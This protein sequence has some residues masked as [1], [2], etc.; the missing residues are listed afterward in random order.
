MFVVAYG[1]DQ[2]LF[3]KGQAFREVRLTYF[4]LC[5]PLTSAFGFDKN[6][7]L[8]FRELEFNELSYYKGR[9]KFFVTDMNSEDH[10]GKLCICLYQ[11]NTFAEAEAAIRSYQKAVRSADEMLKEMEEE[12]AL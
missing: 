7:T 3:K 5:D 12:R 2:A 9:E 1:E 4:A 10:S 6:K 8:I 11:V